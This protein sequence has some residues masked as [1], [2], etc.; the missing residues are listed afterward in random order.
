M[1]RSSRELLKNADV[2][3]AV[4]APE[5]QELSYLREGAVLIGSLAPYQNPDLLKALC[6]RRIT[7]FSLEFIPRTT[8]AQAM[9]VLS[10]QATVAGYKAVLL[11]AEHAQ[12]FF[13]M[14]TTAGGTVRR[15]RCLLSGRVVAG[16]Q[17]IA[18]AN[19]LEP[20]CLAT[21][22]DL[23]LR[24]KSNPSGRKRSMQAFQPKER[25]ATHAN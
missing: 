1:H 9:D 4:Q 6:Q 14:L 12:R 22:F 24:N 25:E 11:G 2:V 21:T 15:P 3:L 10:S 16:L 18:T 19:A 13:C 20:L 5:I 8:R 17:A 23:R 7:S